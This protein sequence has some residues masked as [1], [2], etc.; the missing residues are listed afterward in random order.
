MYFV[1]K[2]VAHAVSGVFVTLA[3]VAVFTPRDMVKQRLQL[4]SRPFKEVLD[5]M[6][7]FFFP[8][9]LTLL[10]ELSDFERRLK[11]NTCIARQL[12]APSGGH[13]KSSQDG[14]SY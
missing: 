13:I 4:S 10:I 1:N 11:D 7:T 12:V 6:K 8:L 5:C 2:S 3:S 9:F 14:V